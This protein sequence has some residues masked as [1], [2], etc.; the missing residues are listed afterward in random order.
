MRTELILG[1]LVERYADVGQ[2]AFLVWLRADAQL[3][4]P[5]AFNVITGVRP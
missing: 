5:G 3:S 2:I 4:Q 1:T